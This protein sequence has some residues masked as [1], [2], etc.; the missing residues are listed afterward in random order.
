MAGQA[1]KAKRSIGTLLK[2]GNGDGPPETFSTIGDVMAVNLSDP[3]F[4]EIE[5]TH[6]N[7]PTDAA[8]NVFKEIIFGLLDPGSATLELNF[9]GADG[10]D[11]LIAAAGAKKNF[12]L[13]MPQLVV[14]GT[15][16][17]GVKV[18]FTANV[19]W[20]MPKPAPKDAVKASV[21]L[22]ITGAI[23]FVALP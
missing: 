12:E 19:G 21:Q 8:G 1:S 2:I 4:D 17:N 16:A 7:S 13:H 23:S 10:Q 18:T 11:K 6:L 9:T 3:K 22:R 20:V 15:W 5:V 14:A